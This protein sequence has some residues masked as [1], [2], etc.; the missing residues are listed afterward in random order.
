M[1]K[2]V[3][4]VGNCS[5][6]HSK[7][8][9]VVE[10]HFAAEVV[11]ARDWSDAR[12]ELDAGPAALVLVN[13]LLDADGSDGVEFIRRLKADPRGTSVPCM[14]ISNYDEYQQ[15]AVEAGAVRGFGKAELD[16]PSTIEKLRTL[17]A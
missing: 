9:R 10:T 6:D 7:I 14:L 2:K 13:R 11:C 5:A 4:D 12:A 8:R 15:R 16:Q 17:L 1:P 3:I